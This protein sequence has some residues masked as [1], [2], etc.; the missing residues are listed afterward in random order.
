MTTDVSKLSYAELIQLKKQLEEQID[1]KRSEE[2][3]VLADG[4]VKKA[5]AA[6]FTALEAFEAVRPYLPA[7]GK[8]GQPTS[9]AG[10][11][12][13]YRDPAN[14]QLTWSGRGR[15]PGWLV[16]YEEQGSARSEFKVDG[17]A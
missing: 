12:V 16:A 10:G 5:Q 3:K 8:R 13:V 2:I 15:A 14:P 9:Q 1:A 17:S 4:Y 6:G 11:T 7:S